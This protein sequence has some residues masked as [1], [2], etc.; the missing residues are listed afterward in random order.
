ML[1]KSVSFLP[2]SIKSM[3]PMQKYPQIIELFACTQKVF[4]IMFSFSINFNK[5]IVFLIAW[6]IFI[7]PFISS[8]KIIKVV[9]PGPCIFF[10]IPASI[11]EVTAVIPG[12]GKIVF[13]RR[14]CYFH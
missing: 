3:N 12:E 13:C 6:T 14:N 7:L 8:F 4:A 9:A 1:V 10:W 2:A 5:I 11:S